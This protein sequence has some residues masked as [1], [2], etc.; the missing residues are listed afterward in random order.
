MC[1]I[2]PTPESDE[3]FLSTSLL[4]SLSFSGWFMPK[5]LIAHFSAIPYNAILSRPADISRWQ[6]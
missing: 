3:A 6:Q 2:N 5:W 1:G 4:T